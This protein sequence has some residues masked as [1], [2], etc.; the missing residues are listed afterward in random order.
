MSISKDY[1][2]IL[3]VPRNA[4]DEQIKKAFRKLAF[5][6]HPDHNKEASAEDRFK[7]INEAYE[8]LSDARKRAYYDRYGRVST[9]DLFG[10]EDFT[11]GGLGDIFDAFFG[12]TSTRPQHRIP[13]KGADIRTNL[14]ISFEEAVFGTDKQFEIWRVENCSLC[15]GIGSHPG[16]NP[17]KC[18][19]CNGSGQIRRI[20]PSLFGRFVHSTT[21]PQCHGEGS[22]ITQ[23]C[24]QCKGSG[25]EKVKRKLIATIPPGIDE[26]H[27]IRLSGEGDAGKYGGPPGDVYI[28][29][30]IKPH[31]LFIRKGIDIVYELPIN[32]AQAA[33]GDEVEVPLLNGKTILKIPPGT[34]TG[35]VFHLKGKGVPHLNGRG[36]GDQLVLIRVVTPESLD[37]NQRRLFEE[38]A[39]VLPKAE[40]LKDDKHKVNREN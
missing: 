15:H 37:S 28:N 8:V 6:Y 30:S 26:N 4:T 9:S 2:E 23:P 22:V 34:Q 31:K 3:G 25:K 16:T 39:K 29:V 38:L 13:Q 1:Y 32:F 18:P 24:R 36:R 33:L 27:Q 14:I 35:K 7:E 10:F 20:Q 19:N 12:A 17:Q 21:C 40:I 11:F 5:K